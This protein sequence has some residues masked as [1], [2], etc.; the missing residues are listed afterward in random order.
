MVA[1]SI[2]ALTGTNDV[3]KGWD[4][5]FRHFNMRHGKGKV[6][7]QPGEIVTIK[8]NLTTCNILNTSNVDLN[9]YDKIE[10]LENKRLLLQRY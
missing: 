2:K 7:Y 3:A 6:G 1:S 4:A 5:L 8:I 10:F 9:T